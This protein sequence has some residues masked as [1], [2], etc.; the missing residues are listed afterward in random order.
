VVAA[1]VDLN[2]QPTCLRD[3]IGRSLDDIR[4]A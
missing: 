1:A 2:R 4:A 3:E